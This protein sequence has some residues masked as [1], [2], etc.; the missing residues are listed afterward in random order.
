MFTKEARKRKLE[1]NGKKIRIE[2]AKESF[3]CYGKNQVKC[4]ACAVARKIETDCF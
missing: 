4:S 3:L 1:E 2:L